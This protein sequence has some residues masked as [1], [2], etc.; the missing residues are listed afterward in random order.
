M[1]SVRYPLE[2]YLEV[3]YLFRT[4]TRQLR[5]YSLRVL[6]RTYLLERV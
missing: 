1:I 6:D 5:L 2:T 3:D 4:V